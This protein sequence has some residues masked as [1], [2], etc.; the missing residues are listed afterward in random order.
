MRKSARVQINI[1]FGLLLATELIY[2][3]FPVA[4]FN[5]PFSANEN[6]LD[7]QYGGEDLHDGHVGC[8]S[9][10]A[11]VEPVFSH[12]ICQHKFRYAHSNKQTLLAHTFWIC[13]KPCT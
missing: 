5:H 10:D 8:V 6:E 3:L 11:Q 9:L 12:L 4:C 7:L 2:R 1:S 13:T